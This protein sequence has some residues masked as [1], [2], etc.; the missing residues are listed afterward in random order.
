[1]GVY[2]GIYQSYQLCH[3]HFCEASTSDVIDVPLLAMLY[4]CPTEGLPILHSWVSVLKGILLS[5][6]ESWREMVEVKWVQD[7][8][9][10][11]QPLSY[12]SI[13]PVKGLGR[14]SMILWAVMFTYK[15]MDLDAMGEASKSDF[16]RPLREVPKINPT[17]SHPI[18]RF[19]QYHQNPT[20]SN[21]SHII[22][23]KASC[24]QFP[25]FQNPNVMVW[26]KPSCWQLFPHYPKSGQIGFPHYLD[27]VGTSGG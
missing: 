15:N 12:A 2:L 6:F 27:N 11:D 14:V 18:L 22:H 19:P 16:L 4:K 9:P 23:I 20:L 10:L 7:P 24:W 21:I 26:V 3:H 17:L 5:G 8:V 13:L 25:N 1:M